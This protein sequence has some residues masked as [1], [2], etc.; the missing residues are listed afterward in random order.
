MKTVAERLF[1]LTIEN[2]INDKAY[3][4]RLTFLGFS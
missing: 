3:E 4:C 2:N 1:N